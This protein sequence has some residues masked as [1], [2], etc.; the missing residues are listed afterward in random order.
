[1][2][3]KYLE[4]IQNPAAIDTHELALEVMEAINQS[5]ASIDAQLDASAI[6]AGNRKLRNEE[7]DWVRRAC[8]ALAMKKRDYHKVFQRDRELRG[9]KGKAQTE[10][11]KDK[12][13]ANLLKQERL[14]A[15]AEERRVTKQHKFEEM[16]I[17]RLELEQKARETKLEITRL[18]LELFQKEN[19]A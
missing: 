10:A 2:E 8:F 1:M 14:K 17:K 16:Q 5:I 13:A 4:F 3:E 11:N 6:L 15:E 18:K 12:Y 9:T 19:P 7:E